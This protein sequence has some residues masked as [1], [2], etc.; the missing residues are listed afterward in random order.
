MPK[1][2]INGSKVTVGEDFMSLSPEEQNAAVDE[3]ARSMIEAYA[4]KPSTSMDMLKSGA[5]GVAR[6]AADL[7][8]LPGTLA[9]VFN[10]G[11]SWL[12]GLPDLPANP[13]SGQVV[14]GGLAAATGGASEYEPQTTAGKYTATVGEFLPGAAAFGGLSPSNLGRF[15]VLPGLTSEGAG[16]LTQG[17]AAEPYARIAGALIG[18][19]LPS[20]A[21]R[22]VTPMP[23]PPERQAMVDALKGEGVPMTAG[24]TTGS[25]MLRYAESELGGGKYA[26]M[27]DDQATAFTDAAMR[28]AGGTGRATPDNM[29]AIRDRLSQGFDDIAARNAVKAD[30]PLVSDMNKV[31]AEYGRVL[32]TEQR[33]IVGNI[34]QDIVDRF[35]AGKG[36]MSGAD[37]QMIRS[38]LTKRA[39]NARGS[40]NELAGAM[41]GLRDALDKAMERSIQPG[42]AGKW[43]ELRR[44]YGNMKT[45]E[46]AATGAGEEAA[47][48]AISPARL[49]VA[50]TTGNQGGYARGEG[51]FAELSRAGNALLQKMPQSGTAP[52]TAVRQMGASLPAM[53]GAGAGAASGGPAGAIAGL[54][55]GNALPAVAG[56]ALLSKPVRAYLQNQLTRPESIADPRYAAILAALLG[57]M[58]QAPQLPAR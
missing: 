18:P 35:K 16:Q 2:T 34:G 31:V 52:R 37:Y 3:I 40:D 10:S 41:R 26:Q 33:Q 14:R 57:Q 28:K 1:I 8:G 48:G 38:R 15:G 27:M 4:D 54:L 46:R 5:S 17:S 42:D 22:M 21:K 47:M 23:I 29:T 7:A 50:A 45:L 32:P 20:L 55:A 30:P 58:P 12:T 11:V 49:R 6:G 44:Q 39:Q 53:V 9:D 36:A 43:S 56:R 51:D 24:Q 19:A 25:N 13:M